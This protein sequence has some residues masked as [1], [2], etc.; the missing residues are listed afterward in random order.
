MR[1]D[2]AAPTS[3]VARRWTAAR[4]RRAVPGAREDV[5][6]ATVRDRQ[7]AVRGWPTSTETALLVDEAAGRGSFGEG[8]I[9]WSFT[10]CAV[11]VSD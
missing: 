7:R 11:A 4:A 9:L 1:T 10:H 5:R 2:R 8:L 3:Y 6:G